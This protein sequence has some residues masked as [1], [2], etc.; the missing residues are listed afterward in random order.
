M[1]ILT[2]KNGFNNLCNSYISCISSKNDQFDSF[3][4][5]NKQYLVIK[6]IESNQI[7]PLPNQIGLNQ[8][9]LNE[10]Y[11]NSLYINELYIG[12]VKETIKIELES[13]NNPSLE[14][15]VKIKN[16]LK[17]IR[18]NGNN[19]GLE[20]NIKK[21]NDNDF[22]DMIKCLVW[23][24]DE[25]LIIW[26]NIVRYKE[27]YYDYYDIKLLQEILESSFDLVIIDIYDDMEKLRI[28]E[29]IKDFIDKLIESVDI[30]QKGIAL[31]YKFKHREFISNICFRQNNIL[32]EINSLQDTYLVWLELL[33][34]NFY[35]SGN[36]IVD[37]FKEGSNILIKLGY[38]L[39]IYSNEDSHLF[40][41]LLYIKLSINLIYADWSQNNKSQADV[42]DLNNLDNMNYYPYILDKL[43]PY[44][45]IVSLMEKW[46]VATDCILSFYESNNIEL[47]QNDIRIYDFVLYF[48]DHINKA[49]FEIKILN[50]RNE[51]INYN[52]IIDINIPEIFH[53]RIKSLEESI[54]NLKIKIILKNNDNRKSINDRSKSIKSPTK[55]WR[56]KKINSY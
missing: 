46:I 23:V 29:E 7:C 26:N 51:D 1:R 44:S 43:I 5:I 42:T 47:I 10:I 16:K 37:R 30:S 20:I 49:L 22:N 13:N 21:L 35:G 14:S 52:K 2:F 8:S 11:E 48:Y 12:I 32:C 56:K 19:N 25:L 4:N 9:I 28:M 41:G 31:Y 54:N 3:N 34:L 40:K 38:K 55:K 53:V 45:S 24:R 33:E 17:D 6:N 18:Q 50:Q 15:I 27:I 39:V 36:G